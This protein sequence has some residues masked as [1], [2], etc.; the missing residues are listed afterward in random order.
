M[1]V[2]ALKKALK[3]ARRDG[4]EVGTVIRW[5][6]NNRYTYV[7]VKTEVGWYTTARSVNRYVDQVLTFEGLVRVLKKAE[8]SNVQVAVGWE[9][10]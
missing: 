7:A 3:K 5:T 6:S 1:S 4:F 9:T 10:V 8:V 2:K